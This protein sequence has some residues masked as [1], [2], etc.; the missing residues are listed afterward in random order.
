MNGRGRVNIAQ[1][2]PYE[3]QKIFESEL[4]NYFSFLLIFDLSNRN[5]IRGI[6]LRKKI[7]FSDFEESGK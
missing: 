6:I 3:V 7:K 5:C 1:E 4:I 2:T